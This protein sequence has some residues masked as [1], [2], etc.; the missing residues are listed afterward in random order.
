MKTFKIPETIHYHNLSV[1]FFNEDIYQ[2]EKHI[3]LWNI[4]HKKL[5]SEHFG[6]KSLPQA[7]K[8]SSFEA[9]VS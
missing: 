1:N 9:T 3:K 8:K 7:G 2:L 5:L 6:I 4:P